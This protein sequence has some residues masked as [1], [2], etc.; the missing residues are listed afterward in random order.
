MANLGVARATAREEGVRVP[1]ELRRQCNCEVGDSGMNVRLWVKLRC[2]AAQE[3]LVRAAAHHI[4]FAKRWRLAWP[5]HIGVAADLFGRAARRGRRRAER[6]AHAYPCAA[7]RRRPVAHAARHN[8]RVAFGPRVDA[9][10]VRRRRSPCRSRG[11]DG[12][13]AT[14]RVARDPTGSQHS[15]RSRAREPDG[16]S[17]TPCVAPDPTGSERP[18][19]SLLTRRVPAHPPHPVP[20]NP[21]GSQQPH[22][23]PTTR[24][25]P[26]TPA[27]PRTRGP[28]GFPAT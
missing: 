22:E 25:V 28:D 24:R 10:E 1:H 18:H 21:T 12:S 19:G 7:R 27:T 9:V 13:A 17:A 5:T 20:A 4:L 23:S 3:H 26:S 16:F 15:D 8:D 11:P 6:R 14:P 2:R